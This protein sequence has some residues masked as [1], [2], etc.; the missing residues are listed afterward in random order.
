[1]NSYIIEGTTTPLSG[2]I[3][4]SGNKNAALPMI[5]ATL[6]TEEEGNPRKCSGNCRCQYNAANCRIYWN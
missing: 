3:T 6:L 4:V 5:A 1:M 2:E